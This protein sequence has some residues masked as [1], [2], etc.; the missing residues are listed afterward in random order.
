MNKLQVKVNTLTVALAC[1]CASAYSAEIYNKDGNKLDL[2]GKIDALHQISDNKNVNGDATYVRL[3][4]KGETQINQLLT[5]YGQWEYQL[6]ANQAEGAGSN[7]GVTRVSFAGLYSQ[8][9]GSIDYGRNYG[10]VYDIAAFTDVLPEFGGDAY[11]IDNFMFK[12][13]SNLLTYRN[14]TLVEGIK[15]VLQYQGENGGAGESNNSRGVLSQNGEGYGA[16]LIKE[17]DNGLSIGGAFS[18]SGRTQDQNEMTYGHGDR[19][20]VYRAGLKYDANQIYL[21]GTFTDTHNATLFGSSSKEVY[22][23]VNH[24]QI[25]ELTAK[26]VFDNGFVPVVSYLQTKGKDLEDYDEKDLL[27]YLAVGAAYYFNKNMS[28]AVMY[29]FNFL[30]DN[31]FTD[32]SGINTDDVLALDLV[33]QF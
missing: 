20:T 21:A 3:G 17:W 9:F 25:V 33:Y 15:I 22:G 27:K 7:T 16:S 18:S 29:K 5:G 10:V 14:D 4:F 2:Y 6:N 32:R 1:F 31:D 28:T 8:E 19:A 12:R 23:F 11:G 13:T 30:K 26:Y 24:A